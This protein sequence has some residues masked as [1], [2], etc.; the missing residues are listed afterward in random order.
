[1]AILGSFDPV[2]DVGSYSPIHHPAWGALAI[3][4]REFREWLECIQLEKGGVIAV[5]RA[6]LDESGTHSQNA[7]L[8]V[9]VCLGTPTQWGHFEREW[10]PIC[11]RL[12]P[13][14]VAKYHA[15][16]ANCSAASV[17]LAKLMAR[18]LMQVG[19]YTLY[20]R[21]YRAIEAPY[22]KSYFGSAYSLAIQMAIFDIGRFLWSNAPSGKRP[23][24]VAYILEAGH[25]AQPSV[26]KVLS[27]FSLDLEYKKKALFAS[28]TWSP[29]HPILHPADLVAHEVSSSGGLTRV[30]EPIEGISRGHHF[31]LEEI[32]IVLNEIER[33]HKKMK[34]VQAIARNQRKQARK[35]GAE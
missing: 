28:H 8:S 31:T 18:R 10:R 11:E 25:V 33:F 21:D 19:Y 13:G 20:D 2:N 34:R 4:G 5:L 32:R 27:R 1:M 16:E 12:V 30:L 17:E 26:D 14:G 3:S 22:F 9:G 29:K 6:T 23:Q 7:L 15:K 24:G 35:S